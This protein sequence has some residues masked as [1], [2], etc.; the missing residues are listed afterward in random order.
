MGQ[1]LASVH[2]HDAQWAAFD[3]AM[4]AMEQAAEPM[5]VVLGSEGR[6]RVV[7][8]GDKSEAFCRRTYNAMRDN[9]S[10]IP[11]TVDLDEMARD[12][13]SHNELTQRR[14]RLA[15]FMEKIR[16]TDIA[17]GSD[18]MV[19]ALTGYALL[20][21]TGRTEGLDN[22][23]RELGKRFERSGRRRAQPVREAA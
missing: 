22:L 20:K 7:R 1:N 16:D 17:L 3:A 13:A 15:Q 19:A 12:F 2:L 23:Q 10:L 8:M 18:V 9:A 14:L 5:L 21:L 11:T 4:T 6:R